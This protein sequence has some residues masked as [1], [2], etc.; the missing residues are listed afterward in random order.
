VKRTGIKPPPHPRT[1][2]PARPGTA[3]GLNDTVI[4]TNLSAI[5]KLTGSKVAACSCGRCQ[6]ARTGKR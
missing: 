4:T 2:R 3:R 6:A 5:C 1:A